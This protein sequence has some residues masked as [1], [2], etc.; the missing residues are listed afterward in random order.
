MSEETDLTNITRIDQDPK[1]PKRIGQHGWWVRLQRGGIKHQHFFNDSKFGGKEKCLEAAITF[2]D[3]VKTQF[4]DNPN[5]ELVLSGTRTLGKRNISGVIGVNRTE[6]TYT[7]RGKKYKALVWQAHWPTGK[8][9]QSNKTFSIKKYGEEEAFRLALNA[10]EE[11]VAKLERTLHPA[12]MPP[13]DLNEK[14]W[15][16]MDFTKFISLLEESALFF[17]CVS[18]LN[19]PFEGSLSKLNK[20]LRPLIY[21]NKDPDTVSSLVINLRNEVAVNCWHASDY[22]SA[23]MWELYSKS[24]ESVCIQSSYQKLSSVIGN[25]AEI[26]TVQYVD[27]TNEYIPEH[28]PYLV[29]LHKRKSFEHESEVRAIIKKL[30]NKNKGHGKMISVNLDSLIEKI[31]VSPNSPEWFLDLVTKTVSRYKLNK[32]V[33]QSSLADDPVY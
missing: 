12:F 5:T 21:K 29:F 3:A 11:G 15:R 20:Q 7:K 33:I 23:A 25:N 4:L 18:K 6:Y 26:G 22:E 19:D 27:Y 32:P 1:P 2:R 31:F 13:A 16:Y 14:L 10:R 9:K 17:S 8:G 24:E 28:D 30:S